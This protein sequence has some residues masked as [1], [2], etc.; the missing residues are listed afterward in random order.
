MQSLRWV[1]VSVGGFVLF[2]SWFWLGL[3][4]EGA[5]QDRGQAGQDYADSYVR[6]LGVM[7]VV[8][9][10]IVVLLTV[11]SLGAWS[12]KHGGAGI[13]SAV[14]TCAAASVAGLLLSI[15]LFAPVPALP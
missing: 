8:T 14:L 13:T 1:A 10:H 6:E 9:A 5:R 7:P 12:R 15:P 11:V 3:T 4:V 2:V